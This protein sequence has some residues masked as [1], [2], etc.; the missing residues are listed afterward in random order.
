MIFVDKHP[1][2][3]STVYLINVFV[4]SL[5]ALLQVK[6]MVLGRDR[7]PELGF[8]LALEYRSSVAYPSRNKNSKYNGEECSPDGSLIVT[9]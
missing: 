8:K 2:N 4:G 3:L 1:N 9:K 7:R 5:T 6:N